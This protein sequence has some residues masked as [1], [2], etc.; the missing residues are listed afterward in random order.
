MKTRAH[1]IVP[2]LLAPVLLIAAEARGGS[3]ARPRTRSS[4]RATTQATLERLDALG[5]R[6]ASR[7]LW[8]YFTDKGIP[9]HA[10]FDAAR[11]RFA[12]G[13]G[14]HARERRLKTFGASLCDAR[15]LPLAA[16]YRENLERLGASIVRESRWLNAVSI[17]APLATVRSIAALPFVS[18]ITFV[19]GG[20]SRKSLPAESGGQLTGG[21]R[22]PIDY[23]PS[24][25]QLDEIGV[26]AVHALGLTGTGII[27]AMLDTGYQRKHPAFERIL[28]EGRILAQWDFIN[29]DGETQNEPGDPPSQDR[30]GTATWSVLAA[31]DEGDLIG[32]AFGAS[33]LLAKTEDVSGE[34][35]IEEDNWVAGME[36]ADAL[37]ADVISSS[38]SYIDWYQ[39]S[40]MDG[41]TAV[42]TIGADIAASRGIIVCNSAGNW[43][44]QDWYYIGAPSDGD[45]VIAVGATRPDGGLWDDSSHGPTY[46]GRIKPE[47]CARGEGTY[48]AWPPDQGGPYIFVSGTSVSCPLAA[49]CAALVLQA[50]PSWT[51]MQVRE[52]LMTTADNAGTPNND[53]GWGR[54]D[55]LAALG[56]LAAVPWPAL[57]GVSAVRLVAEPN[58][59]AGGSA[60]TLRAG[61]PTAIGPAMIDLFSAAGERLTRLE[62]RDPGRGVVWAGTDRGGRS[63]PPGIYFARL[64]SR[65]GV[66]T[67]K[68]IRLRD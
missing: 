15:D 16:G 20:R 27:V 30:H 64:S 6:A 2:L 62:S 41:D 38:L 50:H 8:V 3:P 34:T 55:V 54:I 43:G 29:D 7:K 12:A 31:F 44:T 60:V 47:V 18:R 68:L 65:A 4:D 63:L 24:F 48:C 67:V 14:A 56:D 39:Y 10:A 9:D 22:D 42:S 45:S 51:A 1:R 21:P 53:R 25:G 5:G 52:A 23:G 58:P 66:G 32:P 46:D 19:G 57:G 35:P 59:S 26:P 40:D 49:G 17:R 61:G 13:L 36:W 33:F 37:G 28:A 11:D